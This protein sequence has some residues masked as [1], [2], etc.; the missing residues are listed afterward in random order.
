LTENYK[1]L[2][3]VVDN[4]CDIL[5]LFVPVLVFHEVGVAE[6]EVFDCLEAE[7]FLLVVDG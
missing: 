2:S 7:L 3:Q 4:T 5:K 1:A 6:V